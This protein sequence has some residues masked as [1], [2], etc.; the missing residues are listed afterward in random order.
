ML[1]VRL[2][3]PVLLVAAT[4]AHA[5]P[6]AEKLFQDGR[7]ALAAGKLD[8]ACDAFRRSE[9]LEPKVGTLLNLGDCEEKRGH[10]AAA[11]AT[12]VEAHALAARTNDQRTGEAQRRTKAL[13]PKLAYLTIAIAER[14]P[15]MT[16]KRDGT[17][18]ADAEWDHEV[19]VDPKTMTIEVAAPGHVGWTKTIALRQGGKQ[20]IDVPALAVDPSAGRTTSPN[21]TSPNPTSPTSPNPTNPANPTSPNPTHPTSPNPTNPTSP[22]RISPNPANPTSPNPTNPTSPNP[23]SPTRISP[24]APNPTSPNPTS[25]NP[26]KP[27][28]PTSPNRIS[29]NPANPTSPNPTSPD[30]TNPTS[31]DP[32]TSPNPTSP[33]SGVTT[34]TSVAAPAHR[35]IAAGALVGVSSD[36]D[37]LLGGR[38]VFDLAPA[39]PGWVRAVV[40]T[41]YTRLADSDPYH[42]VRLY[43]PSLAAEYIAGFTPQLYLAGG[44]GFGLDVISDNY[45]NG[46]ATNTWGALRASPTVRLGHFDLGLHLQLVYASRPILLGELGLDYFLW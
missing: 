46:L 37:F 18:V 28:N 31:P 27:A 4:V 41:M 32:T 19:P 3:A 8:E 14:A 24:N 35:R 17:A 34:A 38:A 11:W 44:A 26:T 16:V 9:E 33:V 30:P 21:P 29:P 40:Q 7:I 22:N 25:P 12:F 42:E 45:Q 1:T 15:G 20:R 36:N 43:A 5:S 10:V 2:W 23:T 6:A 39:G 13:A